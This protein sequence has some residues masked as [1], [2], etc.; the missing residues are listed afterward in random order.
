[1]KRPSSLSGSLALVAPTVLLMGSS[2]QAAIDAYMKID[3]VEGEATDSEHQKW[4]ELSSVSFAVARPVTFTSTGLTSDGRPSQSSLV[5]SKVVDKASPPLFLKCLQGDR[6]GQIAFD[7]VPANLSS[8]KAY[9]RIVL[10][11]VLISS[12][13]Q[14]QSED[15]VPTEEVSLN[16]A[17]IEVTYYAIDLKTGEVSAS[18]TS[19]ATFDFTAVK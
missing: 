5:I 17:K 6:I 1:M 3:G 2:S 11:D 13:S 9:Y 15:A 12:V 18:P 4:V 19:E 8:R 14:G 16:Y 10:E 7:F